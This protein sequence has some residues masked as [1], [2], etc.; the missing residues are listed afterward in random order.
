MGETRNHLI[1]GA[2]HG[3]QQDRQPDQSG[4]GGVHCVDDGGS[5]NVYTEVDHLPASGRK[6]HAEDVLADF[7][8]VSLHGG[9]DDLPSSARC[10]RVD[11]RLHGFHPFLDDFPRHDQVSQKVISFFEFPSNDFQ[12]RADPSFDD[13]FGLDPVSQTGSNTLF[14]SVQIHVIDRCCNRGQK[15]IHGSPLRV[16][17]C[18]AMSATVV[19]RS[20]RKGSPAVL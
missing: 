2:N 4:T 20:P 3:R 10:C 16:S 11:H 14:D 8:D 5:R 17:R 7:V 13:L 9:E 19:A 12:T 1:D 15:F 18:L 6:D